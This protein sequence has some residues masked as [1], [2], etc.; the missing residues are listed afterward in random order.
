MRQAPG[1]AQATRKHTARVGPWGLGQP[2]DARLHPAPR[3][4]A[5]ARRRAREGSAAPGRPS[6]GHVALCRPSV[7]L[8]LAQ[9]AL[10]LSRPSG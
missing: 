6:R 10:G 7:A 1:E 4:T 3:G 5:P 8:A 2:L 9:A